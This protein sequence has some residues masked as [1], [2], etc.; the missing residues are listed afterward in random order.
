MKYEDE[1]VESV[2]D[3]LF[4]RGAKFV[5]R[6][7]NSLGI[8]VI[9]IITLLLFASCQKEEDMV[10]KTCDVNVKYWTATM[11][12]QYYIESSST[13]CDQSWQSID[14]HVEIRSGTNSGVAWRKTSTTTCHE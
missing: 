13:H 8:F 9:I 11:G 12:N 5:S 7:L 3:L 14:G 4:G 1:P 10:C 2:D 6:I